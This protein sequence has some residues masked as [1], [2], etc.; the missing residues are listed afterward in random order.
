M[1]ATVLPM[2]SRRAPYR[3]G[4]PVICTRDDRRGH[5]ETIFANKIGKPALA[6]VRVQG[7]FGLRCLSFADFRPAPRRKEA[8]R[9]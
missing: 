9:G 6:A 4:D 1:T 2:P 7:G 5:I 3:V 8:V